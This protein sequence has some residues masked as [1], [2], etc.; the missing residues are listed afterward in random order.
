MV[1][2]AIDQGVNYV[3][4]AYGYHGGNSE[5]FLGRALKDG[6]REKV[7]YVWFDAP[8]GYIS[9]TA[10]HTDDWNTSG[11]RRPTMAVESFWT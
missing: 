3:D 10:N 6:Y 9:I 2:Y 7:F 11:G 8:I 4:T 1:R 5:R